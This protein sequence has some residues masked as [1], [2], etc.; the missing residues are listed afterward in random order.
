MEGNR[1]RKDQ[2]TFSATVSYHRYRC[3]YPS[4]TS[5]LWERMVHSLLQAEVYDPDSVIAAAAAP[6]ADLQDSYFPSQD[7]ELVMT[8]A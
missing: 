4:P 2:K 8:P 1:E 3:P 6:A 7:S 5:W